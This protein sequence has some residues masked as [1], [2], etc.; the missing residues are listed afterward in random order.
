MKTTRTRAKKFKRLFNKGRIE[1]AVRCFRL[2]LTKNKEVVPILINLSKHYRL[3]ISERKIK[4][5]VNEAKLKKIGVGALET[6]EVKHSK[7]KLE[8]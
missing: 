3:G 8:C 7:I 6:Y 2:K 4:G 5:M 1:E